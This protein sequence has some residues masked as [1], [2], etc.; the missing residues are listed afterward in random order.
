MKQEVVEA[1]QFRL[2]QLHN[3]G[4]KMT[5]QFVAQMIAKYCVDVAPIIVRDTLAVPR[6]V[7]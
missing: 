3:M 1:I 5:D 7:T 2:N 4:Y 6:E